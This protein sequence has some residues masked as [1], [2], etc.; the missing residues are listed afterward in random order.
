VL[1]YNARLGDPETQ[2]ILVRLESDF[3]ELVETANSGALSQ[4]QLEWSE[5]TSCCVVMCSR[6]YPDKVV[7]AGARISGV[8]E[9][10]QSGSLRVFHSSTARAAD[11]ALVA[12]GGRVLGVTALGPDL[13]SASRRAYAAAA[14][15]HWEGEHHRTDIGAAA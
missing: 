1:E 9:L 5:Q 2:A 13:A 11:G 4:I 10:P 15:I 8:E 3:L 12:A 7:A 6:G 14:L